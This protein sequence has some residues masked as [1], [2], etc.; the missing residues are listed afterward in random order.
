M[1]KQFFN[2]EEQQLEFEISCIHDELEATVRDITSTQ[3]LHWT[4]D[5]ETLL[6]ILCK[7]DKRQKMLAKLKIVLDKTGKV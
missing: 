2:T 1:G 3:D 7:L 5:N 4:R 6:K